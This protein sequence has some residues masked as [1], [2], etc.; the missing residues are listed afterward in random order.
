MSNPENGAVP[1]AEPERLRPL[2][3]IRTDLDEVDQEVRKLRRRMDLMQKQMD[4]LLHRRKALVDEEAAL[5]TADLIA[6]AR[7]RGI[8]WAALLSPDAPDGKALTRLREQALSGLGIQGSGIWADNNQPALKI[9]LI[10]D[11]KTCLDR[12]ENAIRILS[13]ALLPH[14]DGMIWWGVLE[15]TLSSSGVHL[16]KTSPDLSRAVL[17]IRT[18]G[19]VR[20]QELGNLRAALEHIQKHH[21]YQ[22][23]EEDPDDEHAARDF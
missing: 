18:Y 7:E 10:R 8:D 23:A 16:L 21:W 14:A 22:E 13:P 3:A 6:S 20:N 2:G 9:S 12:T 15:Q 1:V 19:R 11:S 5:I 17:S 4:R